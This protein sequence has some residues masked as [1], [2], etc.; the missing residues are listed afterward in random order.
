[1]WTA[2]R[3][4]LKRYPSW[5]DALQ[6][7]NMR[8]RRIE[9]LVERA[10]DAFFRENGVEGGGDALMNAIMEAWEP[11]VE[12]SERLAFC[13]AC[14]MR[15]LERIRGQ[16]ENAKL[17]SLCSEAY[18]ECLVH[19]RLQIEGAA[20]L[21]AI[22]ADFLGDIGEVEEKEGDVSKSVEQDL[23]REYGT[24]ITDF[25]RE[26]QKGGKDVGLLPKLKAALQLEAKALDGKH[27]GNKTSCEVRQAVLKACAARLEKIRTLSTVSP[28]ESSFYA[29]AGEALHDEA[30]N[31]EKEQQRS[32]AAVD[33]DV[34]GTVS[35]RSLGTVAAA[36]D[37]VDLVEEDTDREAGGVS[38]C[39]GTS[40]S[41][42]QEGHGQ[43]D[44]VGAVAMEGRG[45]KRARAPSVSAEVVPVRRS[46]RVAARNSQ[47]E[48]S[49]MSEAQVPSKRRRK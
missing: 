33:A 36:L 23:L 19:A 26:F 14:A 4:E 7:E 5:V 15:A 28:Q 17:V 11:E 45:S 9:G 8:R 22:F 46:A 20:D 41:L 37:I 10:V 39:P 44:A 3:R 31:I 13:L 6:L 35:S 34:T 12:N 2:P 24:M 40:A 29:M 21:R 38:S 47:S 16:S 48:G 32:S 49:V 18:G 43:S 42:G 25:F 27:Q 30:A 1:M